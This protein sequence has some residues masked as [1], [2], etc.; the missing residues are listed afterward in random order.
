MSIGKG[1]L[2]SDVLIVGRYGGCLHGN[3]VGFKGKV[4]Y[5]LYSENLLEWVTSKLVPWQEGG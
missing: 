2:T 1:V 3:I 5:M 4:L